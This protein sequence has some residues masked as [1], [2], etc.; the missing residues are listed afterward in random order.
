MLHAP[1]PELSPTRP[2]VLIEKTK[3]D[4]RFQKLFCFNKIVRR[5]FLDLA[6]IKHQSKAVGKNAAAKTRLQARSTVASFLKEQ[7]TVFRP[8]AMAELMGLPSFKKLA[9]NS[10]KKWPNLERHKC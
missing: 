7:K 10:G 5:D 4:F 1:C 9:I 2:R 8:I 3:S 6:S